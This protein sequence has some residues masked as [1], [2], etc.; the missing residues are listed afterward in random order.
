M[1]GEYRDIV[2][3]GPAGDSS[4]VTGHIEVEPDA[5]TEIMIQIYQQSLEALKD[6]LSA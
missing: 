1:R 2:T 4:H 3:L 6:H 5:M